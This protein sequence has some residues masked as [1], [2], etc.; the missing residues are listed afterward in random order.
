MSICGRC[1]CTDG[2]VAASMA[3]LPANELGFMYN[4]D[5][6]LV[7]HRIA[8]NQ[9]NTSF[10]TANSLL[11]TSHD[12]ILTITS[13]QLGSTTAPMY[14]PHQS[15][16]IQ[17]LYGLEVVING[18]GDPQSAKSMIDS[19]LQRSYG[20]ATGGAVVRRS[21]VELEGTV[22]CTILFTPQVTQNFLRDP[23]NFFENSGIPSPILISPQLTAFPPSFLVTD[24]LPPQLSTLH[25]NTN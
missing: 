19:Y 5:S 16:F 13:L 6:A 12:H 15:R 9:N 2:Y 25:H 4:Q 22:Y 20:D 24:S 17:L 8:Q 1:C 11:S 21:R 23:F 14:L 18:V 7:A 10:Q 3:G